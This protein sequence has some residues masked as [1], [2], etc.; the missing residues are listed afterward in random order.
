MHLLAWSLSN[1]IVII[2]SLV[3]LPSNYK[4]ATELL[5][6]YFLPVMPSYNS[7]QI[8]LLVTFNIITDRKIPIRNYLQYHQYNKIKIFI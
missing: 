3:T 1:K 8:F 7:D 2:A 5:T 4:I 6:K